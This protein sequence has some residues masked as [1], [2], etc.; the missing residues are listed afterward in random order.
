[1]KEW[2]QENDGKRIPKRWTPTQWHVGA[3]SSELYDWVLSDVHVPDMVV[4]SPYE[5]LK[6][7]FEDKDGVYA[8]K[9]LNPPCFVVILNGDRIFYKKQ[10]FITAFEDVS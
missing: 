2:K 5:D 3:Q 4:E 7:E 8:C 6:A 9:I 1:M 10:D